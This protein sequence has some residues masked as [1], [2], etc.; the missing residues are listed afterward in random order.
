MRRHSR[1]HR[2]FTL[3]ELLSVIG[4]IAVL[5]ALLF[6]AIK[7]A[8]IKAEVTR[9]QSGISNLSTALRAYYTE[10]GKWPVTDTAYSS[11]IIDQ[12][13]VAL[14]GG[15]NPATPPIPT[16]YT[17]NNYS[18]NFGPIGT[19]I[20]NGNPRGIH[21]LDF[22][23]SDL[24]VG[25]TYIDPWKHPYYVRFDYTYADLVEDPFTGNGSALK[26]NLSAGFLIWSSGPDNLYDNY[27]DSLP[28]YTISPVN[29]DNVKSW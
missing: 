25:G 29:V 6:P 1:T 28:A 20:F 14:L 4:I 27:G 24:D 18:G 10:Y 13:F 26:T 3:I 7:S 9:A 5:V 2:G 22:K 19:A 17:Y 21:F 16:G 12:N 15:A 23:A 8:L 11:Y